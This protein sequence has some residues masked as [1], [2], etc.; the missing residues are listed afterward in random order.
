MGWAT[1]WAIFSHK[2]VLGDFHIN[3][4]GAIFSHKWVLVTLEH[5]CTYIGGQ[6]DKKF[7]RDILITC[8]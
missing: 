7:S 8:D 3:G 4:F 5:Y 2:W 1:F 6:M